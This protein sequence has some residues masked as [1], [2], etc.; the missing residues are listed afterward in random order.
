M[1]QLDGK[2]HVKCSIL[3]PLEV[4]FIEKTKEKHTFAKIDSQS[5]MPPLGTHMVACRGHPGASPGHLGAL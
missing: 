4:I 1:Q 2:R 3:T 5:K